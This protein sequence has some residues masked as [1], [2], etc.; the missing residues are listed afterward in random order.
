MTDETNSRLHATVSGRVQ[1]VSFRYFVMEKAD[2]LD[3]RGWVRNRWDGSVEVTAEGSLQYLEQL[4]QALRTGPP[5][6][7]VDHIDYEWLDFTGEFTGF[8]LSSTK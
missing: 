3:L 4:L 7:R 6:A 8:N 5:M 1:G 2:S